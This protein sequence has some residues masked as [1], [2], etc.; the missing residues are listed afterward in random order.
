MGNILDMLP[1][2][3]PVLVLSV[4]GQTIWDAFENS[5]SQY[6]NTEGNFC[7]KS[8]NYSLMHSG[9]FPQ[10]SGCRI[11]F[12]PQRP[13]NHRLISV[14]ILKKHSHRHQSYSRAPSAERGGADGTPTKRTNTNMSTT[15][16]D[17]LTAEE[18]YADFEPL[19]L[20]KR[21]TLAVRS[22]TASGNDGFTMLKPTPDNAVKVLVDEES[23]WAPAMMLRRLFLGLRTLNLWMAHPHLN[24][25]DPPAQQGIPGLLRVDPPSASGEEHR[26]RTMIKGRTRRNIAHAIRAAMHEQLKSFPPT[27]RPEDPPGAPLPDLPVI[28]PMVD[29]RILQVSSSGAQ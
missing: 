9:R 15:S 4:T 29:G 24:P 5:V 18:L 23:G 27:L 25:V 13:P 16:T 12:D 17:S 1:Y 19:D 10:V 28:G 26:G 22:Y 2:E 7:F 8:C 20:G 6:P 11:C 14:H 3:D 21:Y